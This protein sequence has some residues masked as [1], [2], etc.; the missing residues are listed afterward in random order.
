M[1][2]SLKKQVRELKKTN[3]ELNITI[4]EMG[5]DYKYLRAQKY[6]AANRE[7]RQELVSLNERIQGL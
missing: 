3:G 4:V 7:L 2:I 5:K 1:L 6:G